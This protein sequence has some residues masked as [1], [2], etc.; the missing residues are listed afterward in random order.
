MVGSWFIKFWNF[1]M[2]KL[3]LRLIV[4]YFTALASVLL[5]NIFEL[6][7]VILP[8]FIA[9]SIFIALITPLNNKL[10]VRIILFALFLVNLALL[11]YKAGTMG[12]AVGVFNLLPMTLALKSH[13]NLRAF[14]IR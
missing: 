8:L 14:A 10:T 4:L 11:T 1:D 13:G 5:W 7:D 6:S 3:Q 9:V 2:L 12:M